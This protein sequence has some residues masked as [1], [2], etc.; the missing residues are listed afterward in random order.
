[1]KLGEVEFS[2]SQFLAKQKFRDIKMQKY[3]SKTESELKGYLERMAR[4]QM[5]HC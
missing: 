2:Q 4:L 3:S 5:G 1:M